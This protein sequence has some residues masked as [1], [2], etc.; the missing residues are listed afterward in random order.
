MIITIVPVFDF[1]RIHNIAVVLKK[2]D[3]VY[4]HTH[5]KKTFSKN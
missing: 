2:A 1:L 3:Y 4:T 5:R